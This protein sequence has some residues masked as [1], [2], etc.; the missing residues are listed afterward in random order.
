MNVLLDEN[1]SPSLAPRMAELG[2]VARHVVHIGKRGLSDP[3]LW[4]LA[5]AHDEI[6]VTINAA[7]FLRLAAGVE[8]HPGLVVLRSRGLDRHAQWEWIR[9]VFERLAAERIDLTNTVVEVKGPRDFALRKV[10][11]E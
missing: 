5:F 8:L 7:D 9:P 1:L 2:I 6:V 4:N 11:A 10:P 3:E